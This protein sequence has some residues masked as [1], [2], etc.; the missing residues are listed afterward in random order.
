MSNR[1]DFETFFQ[2][3]GLIDG[4]ENED[5]VTKVAELSPVESESEGT[6]PAG[7]PGEDADEGPDARHVR[8]LLYAS[9]EPVEDVTDFVGVQVDKPTLGAIRSRLIDLGWY[10]DVRV[11]VPGQEYVV[12][13][14]FAHDEPAMEGMHR[15]GGA[16]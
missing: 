2:S 14:I 11:V 1:V 5:T 16:L 12:S 3:V 13:R 10:A 7:E 15:I 8:L 9:G 6:E 4:E